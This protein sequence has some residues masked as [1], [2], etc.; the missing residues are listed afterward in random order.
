MLGGLHHLKED[1][2]LLAVFLLVTFFGLAGMGYDAMIPAYTQRIVKAGVSGYS[3][4]MACGG[5]G[6]TLGAIFVASMGKHGRR[7]R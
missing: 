5:I 7:E 4:L 3:V 6:A 2:R 1:R